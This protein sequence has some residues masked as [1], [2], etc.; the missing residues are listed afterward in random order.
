VIEVELQKGD[1][2]LV[3]APNAWHEATGRI[4]DDYVHPASGR[5]GW[6]VV[7]DS[8]ETIFA[9]SAELFRA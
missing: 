1:R 6:A 5:V 2:V 7:V 9:T 8:G 4:A 3:V